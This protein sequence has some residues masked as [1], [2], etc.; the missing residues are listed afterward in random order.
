[1]EKNEDLKKCLLGQIKLLEEQNIQLK[2]SASVNNSQEIR[3]NALAI[4]EIAKTLAV[5]LY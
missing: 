2:D 4:K 3:A 5:E 1:M